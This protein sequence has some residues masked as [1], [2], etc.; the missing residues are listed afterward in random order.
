MYKDLYAEEHQQLNATDNTTWTGAGIYGP[1]GPLTTRSKLV[2]YFPFFLGP[3]R[4]FKVLVVLVPKPEISLI[5]VR[6]GPRT[7]PDNFVLGLT[8]SG[9]W[10]PG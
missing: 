2:R 9:S 3:V 1:L 8:D 10:I 6:F 7:G 4:N 5:L